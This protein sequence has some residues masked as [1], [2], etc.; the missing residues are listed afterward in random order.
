MP[1][2]WSSPA[3]QFRATP[4][5]AVL[6]ELARNQVHHFR[7]TQAEQSPAWAQSVES[8]QAALADQDDAWVLLEYPMLRLGKRIDAVVLTD[9]AILVIEFKRAQADGAALR[10]VED[11]GLDLFDFHEHSRGHPVVPM[12]VSEGCLPQP[13]PLLWVGVTP[14]QQTRPSELGAAIAAILLAIGAPPAGCALRAAVWLAGAYRPVPT[15]IEAACMLYHRNGVADIAAARADQRNLHATT[16]ALQAA[17]AAHRARASKVIL[18]VTGIPG[19][20][21]TLCGLNAAFAADAARDTASGDTGIF[22]TGNPSLVHV[23][24]EALARDAISGGANPRI[25]RRRM[26]SVIQ[27][28]PRF[29]NHYLERPTECPSETVMVIDEAQRCWSREHAMRKTRD[30]PTPLTASEPAH[31]LDIAGRHEGFAGIVCLVGSGQEIH[32]GEGGLAE[33]GA[34]LRTRPQWHAA[35]PPDA[36]GSQ[37]ERWQLGPLPQLS[38]DPQLHL[39]VPIRQIRNGAASDWVDAVLQGDAARARAIAAPAGVPFT[40]TRDA[41]AMRD[42]LRALA[43]GERRAGLIASSGGKRLRAEGFGAELPHMDA[44]SVAHWFLDRFPADIRASNALEQVAT[45]FSCQGLELDHAGLCWDADLIRNNGTVDWVARNFVG[46]KWQIIRAAQ[47]RVN[48]VNTYRVLLTRARYE[49]IL[50]VPRGNATDA[51]RPPAVYDAIAAFLAHC[52]ATDLQTVPAPPPT[53]SLQGDLPWAL[54]PN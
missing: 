38:V 17:L 25:A 39:D 18:F 36:A 44:A 35:A 46:T 12:L 31:L 30:K 9:R 7:T 4:V 27:A 20:G 37:D 14:V 40:L 22:L 28:L 24:R 23:L 51:T 42:G 43:R 2:F 29:R 50:F 21:K 41:A 8:L 32:D 6:G 10:Q 54:P 45:E 11:Y 3:R 26:E 53:R 34:A 33:W 47:G 1:A 15:I 52:G 13:P 49:T 19:A 48:Q 5:Q 16:H